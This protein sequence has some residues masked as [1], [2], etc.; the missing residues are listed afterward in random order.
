[1]KLNVINNNH[2]PD[3]KAWYS[4]KP[5]QQYHD[6]NGIPTMWGLAVGNYQKAV[7]L[8]N[9]NQPWLFCDMP[10]WG[11]WNPLKQAVDPCAE[12]YWRICFGDIHV[13]QIRKNL[14]HE[15]IKHIEIKPWRKKQGDYILLAPSSITVNSYIGQRDWEQQTVSWLSSQTDMPIKIRHK[16]RKNGKSGPAYADVPLAED[17]KNAHCVVTSC[18]MVSVDAIIEGI[19]VYCHPRCPANPVSQ[20]IDKFGEPN[21]SNDRQDWLAT[22]SWHQYT[23]KEIENGLFKNMF[24]QM[25]DALR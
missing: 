6:P 7:N 3:S 11:R 25:Y 4:L 18:S 21:Y 5:L 13:T 12:Y 14:S 17:L 2:G 10:Y 19:P 23:Q 8:K 15:R 16:P 1:M 9:N 20:S 22:L 24:E